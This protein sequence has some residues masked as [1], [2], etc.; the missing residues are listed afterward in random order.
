MVVVL[1][2]ECLTCS[3]VAVHRLL[4]ALTASRNNSTQLEHRP[5][6]V[7]SAVKS[8]I[9]CEALP[10][11]ERIGKRPCSLG[12]DQIVVMELCYDFLDV[13]AAAIHQLRAVLASGHV[14]RRLSQIVTKD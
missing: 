10:M 8:L 2:R 1:E 11:H 4:Q 9:V 6:H 3:L 5:S 12:H 13:V 14:R 7:L